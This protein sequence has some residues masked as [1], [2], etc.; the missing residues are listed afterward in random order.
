MWFKVLLSVHMP[1]VAVD[2]NLSEEQ[3]PAQ[4]EAAKA[5]KTPEK[6]K[7]GEA[8][9]S[10]DKEKILGIFGKDT[11]AAEDAIMR[12]NVSQD[13]VSP[14]FLNEV[15][16]AK[17]IVE[18]V[19]GAH[20]HAIKQTKEA[21]SLAIEQVS[22]AMGETGPVT[23]EA[24]P[25]PVVEAKVETP[26]AAVVE[27]PVAVEVPKPVVVEKPVEAPVLKNEMAEQQ[28]MEAA[29]SMQEDLEALQS[30]A[31]E[32]HLN[33]DADF[34][35]PA[36][37][38]DNL[39]STERE[40]VAVLQAKYRAG[41]ASEAHAEALIAVAAESDPEKKKALAKT[42]FELS[43]TS[44]VM[45]KAATILNA[46]YMALPEI[47]ALAAGNPTG[48]SLG[49]QVGFDQ[50]PVGGVAARGSAPGR[51]LYSEQVRGPSS[52]IASI[53]PI[54]SE[55]GGGSSEKPKPKPNAVDRWVRTQFGAIAG[56][57]GRDNKD[58]H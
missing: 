25:A 24:T 52:G 1:Q 9:E 20:D 42:A 11:A 39:T 45:E 29:A 14:A 16:S 12:L 19:K 34:N 35:A 7:L 51:S 31:S 37:E 56:I 46:Q 28:K 13:D 38:L 47:A 8:L 30:F 32:H 4:E 43:E 57:F 36:Q 3:L 17:A 10:G 50:G 23:S 53:K 18:S 33:L 27:A 54:K 58:R 41:H 40:Y 44:K 49:G 48:G 15:P 6:G 26:I 55:G 2:Q 22:A 21:E 5:P